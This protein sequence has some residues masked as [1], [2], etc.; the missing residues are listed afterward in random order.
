MRVLERRQEK[1]QQGMHA[2]AKKNGLKAE[3]IVTCT[4]LP[5]DEVQ[6]LPRT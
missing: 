4:G 3:L 5:W 6:G 2:A 1:R